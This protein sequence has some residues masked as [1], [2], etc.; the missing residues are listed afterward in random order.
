M[1]NAKEVWTPE[2]GWTDGGARGTVS[3]PDGRLTFTPAAER[4]C[5]CNEDDGPC[6][7]HSELLA[8]RDGAALRTADELMSLFVHDCLAIDPACLAPQGR[9]W[10]ADADASIERGRSA[11]SGVAWMPDECEDDRESLRTLVEQVEAYF[12]D[13]WITWD[14]G[15]TIRR[16]NGGPLA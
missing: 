10:L 5:E 4:E 15:Y 8:Q 2:S 13:L 6:E 9:E 1:A 12:A 3:A 7:G 14:D 16:V 11:T